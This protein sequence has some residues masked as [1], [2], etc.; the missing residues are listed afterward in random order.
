MSVEVAIFLTLLAAALARVGIVLL[1][2]AVAAFPEAQARG[3]G[4]PVAA[5]LRSRLGLLGLIL[6]IVGFVLFLTAVSA[7]AAPISVL[8]PIRAF[9]ILVMAFLSLVFLKERLRA[10]EWLGVALQFF[11]IVLV[12]ISLPP[13]GLEPATIETAKLL[14]YLSGLGVLGALTLAHVLFARKPGD[15]EVSY[16]V[17]AGTLL[18][19][20][21][22]HMKV[23]FLARHTE[24]SDMVALSL[25]ALPLGALGGLAVL[26][27]S[28][29]SCRALV[30]TTINF[31]VNQV[32]VIVGGAVALGEPFP[33][34]PLPFWART[35]GLLAIL[36]GVALLARFQ[37]TPASASTA[38]PTA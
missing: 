2:S 35:A 16:G 17:L 32:V 34:D 6:Q 19:I 38:A 29:R 5:L 8:Q 20:A 15:A 37:E 9:G 4:R 21:Y 28:F 1:K 3:F 22:L 33:A 27:R 18:G 11:G 31:V 30:V 36:A 12:G 7:P 10:L 14:G 24:Q 25:A 26:L 13:A 23:L